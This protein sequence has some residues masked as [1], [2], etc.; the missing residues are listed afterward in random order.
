[1][2][3][4]LINTYKDL[5][6]KDK[7]NELVNLILKMDMILKEIHSNNELHREIENYVYDYEDEDDYLP[8]VY[9]N[10]YNLTE[11]FIDY[12]HSLNN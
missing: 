5:S 12:I 1:M 11:N 7:R 9:I 3:N 2:E 4:N 8:E 10:M 6:I